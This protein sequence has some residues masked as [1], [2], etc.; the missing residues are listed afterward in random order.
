MN[1]LGV[2]YFRI[3]AWRLLDAIDIWYNP[4]FDSLKIKRGYKWL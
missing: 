3:S 1:A 4:V 2:P